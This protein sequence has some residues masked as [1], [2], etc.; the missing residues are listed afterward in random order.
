[1][2]KITEHSFNDTYRLYRHRV[3][4]MAFKILK[5]VQMAEDVTQDV[6]I[7][8]LKQPLENT[9][10]HKIQ[11]LCVVARNTALK[12]VAKTKRLELCEK[13]ESLT[14]EYSGQ[15]NDLNKAPHL[16]LICKNA[17]ICSDDPCSLLSNTE[18][19]GERKRAIL[20]AVAKLP[21]RLQK[22]IRLR[23]FDRLS[24]AE[25]AKKTK[26]SIG[27]VGFLLNKATTTLRNKLK[28]ER[29]N[30]NEV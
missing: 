18:R 23:F 4:G 20:N 16:K 24:Y 15:Q 9:D 25:M 8:F 17:V 1:M 6:F 2:T 14:G 27:N 7:K 29:R 12:L 30:L 22:L 28:N 21:I 11:W 3:F 13:I 26:L 19:L 5:D 10:D